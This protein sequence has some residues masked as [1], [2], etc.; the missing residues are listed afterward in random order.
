MK[1]VLVIGNVFPEPTS[2][3]AGTKM[4]QWLHLFKANDFQTVYASTSPQSEFSAG[5]TEFTTDTWLVEMNNSS[6]N[7]QL[8]TFQPDIVLYDRFMVEEQFSWRVRET[9][10]NAVHLLE[11]QDLHFLR[12]ARSKQ[13]P[14]FNTTCKREIASILRVDLAFIISE[15]ELDFLKNNFPFVVDKI[16]YFPL[17]YKAGKQFVQV[18]KRSDFCFIG[19][20][21]HTPNKQAVLFLKTI[22]KDVRKALP[23]AVIHIYGAYPNQQIQQLHNEKEGFLVH[24]R[25]E[26]VTDVFTKHKFLLAPIAFGA[27]LK[28]KLLEAMQYGIVSLTTPM[29]AEGIATIDEWNGKVV[30]LANFTS[31]IIALNAISNYAEL[32]EKGK[33][34]LTQ[35]FN[36]D[37]FT[38]R[39][40]EQI[41]NTPPTNFLTEIMNFHRQQ[42]VRYLSKWIEGKK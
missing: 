7:E 32:Q 24:G 20:F 4:M 35:K 15:F 16:S 13:Q 2:S 28:G 11:T 38:P 30:E 22:W 17:C 21:L 42:S 14:F 10:P 19:N 8:Q 1:K 3:A 12:E 34:I 25:T 36:S 39:I 41:Q 31:E 18:E 37:Y 5:L 23:N 27:G 33:Q 26:S 40:S 29:G 9:V 6:F